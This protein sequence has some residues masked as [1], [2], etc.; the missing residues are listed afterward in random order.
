MGSGTI[1]KAVTKED[2]CG[3]RFLCP[4]ASIGERFTELISPMFEE[5]EVLS[6]QTSNLRQTRDFLLPK[7][8]SGQVS[9]EYLETAAQVS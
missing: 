3:L 9:V 4:E 5:L 1:F 7:L 8:I 6:A 2:I